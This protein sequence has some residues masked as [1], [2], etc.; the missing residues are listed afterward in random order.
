MT[1]QFRND[2]RG[3]VSETRQHLATENWEEVGSVA[4]K[5]ISLSAQF[6]A[7]EAS[8]L[9]AAVESA[10]EHQKI[11]EVRSYASDL[12]NEIERFLEWLKEFDSSNR[13]G[14]PRH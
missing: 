9:S 7:R 1:G 13:D 11:D 8:R 4:H 5:M 3:L 6:G 2:V 12:E 10:V 14:S